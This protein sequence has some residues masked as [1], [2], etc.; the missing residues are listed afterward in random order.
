MIDFTA[1]VIRQFS[2]IAMGLKPIAII[3]LA[4]AKIFKPII[5]R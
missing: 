2:I 5:I 4:M 1:G 3:E